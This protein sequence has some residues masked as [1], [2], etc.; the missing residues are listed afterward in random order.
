MA[1]VTLG[2]APVLSLC[3]VRPLQGDWTASLECAA[4]E[5][6]TGLVELADERIAYRAGVLRAGVVSSLCRAELVGAPGMRRD[7][8]A[9]SYRDA[10]VR[11][12]VS[13][14]L[15]AAGER[16][17][18][19]STAATLSRRLP[20]WTRAR[21]RASEALS[22][23]TDAIGATWRV[24]PTGAVWVGTETWVAA[25]EQ[26]EDTTLEL[27]RDDAAGTVLLA[28]ETIELG[29]GVTL[30]GRRV[31]RVEHA[32]GRGEHLRTLFWDAA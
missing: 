14:I 19:A 12:I 32:F 2:G 23:L 4:E 16:L 29:P 8:P 26:V 31:G 25:S 21:G 11:T 5:A 24:L 30:R 3:L 7:I 28:A 17:D 6:P 27:D 13:D 1:I 20:F 15:S 10:A 22:V 18:A 9:R